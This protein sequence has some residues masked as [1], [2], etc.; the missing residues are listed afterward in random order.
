[1]WMPGYFAHLC[2]SLKLRC[3]DAV[4]MA[5]LLDEKAGLVFNLNIDID[6]DDDE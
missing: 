2:F 1:M 3:V 6:D 5:F 4:L